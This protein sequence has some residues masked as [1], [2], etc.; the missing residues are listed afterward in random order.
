MIRLNLLAPIGLSAFLLLVLGIATVWSVPR[1]GATAVAEAGS[2]EKY[3]VTIH[4]P[5]TPP[6]LETGEIDD[7][8]QPVAVACATCH[9][10]LTPNPATRSAAQLTEFHQGLDVAHGDLSCLSCHNRNDYDTL[11]LADGTSVPFPDVMTLCSQCHGPQARD[12][13]HGAHGGMTGYWDLTKGPRTRNNCVDCHD[14]HGPAFPTVLPV[15]P[16]QDRFPP[17]GHDD[18]SAASK[19]EH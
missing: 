11:G 14:P 2:T 4:R 12:Y 6:A 10:N 16:P 1:E 17:A 19:Q 7:L 8:G 9:S 15:F 13:A 3:P 5:E 18:D